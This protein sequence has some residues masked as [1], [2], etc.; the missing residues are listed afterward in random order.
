MGNLL[1]AGS[2]ISRH[3]QTLG[4]LWIAY[5]GYTLLGWLVALTALHGIFG[6]HTWFMGGPNL[7]HAP[8][9]GGWMVP[10]VTTILVIRAILSLTVGISLVTRQPWGRIF[11]IVIAILTLVKPVTGTVL[12]IYTLW[13]LLG[14]N[15][16]QDY[17]QLCDHRLS[18]RA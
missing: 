10:F 9:F 3:L 5:A 2:R 1:P 15:G 13:V 12:G 4:I 6:A 16:T 11:A 8:F 7:T 18:G 14:P 17:N